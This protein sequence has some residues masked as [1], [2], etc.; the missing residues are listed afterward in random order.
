MLVASLL[1]WRREQKDYHLALFIYAAWR[2]LSA[3]RFSFKVVHG[4]NGITAWRGITWA[5]WAGGRRTNGEAW[6]GDDGVSSVFISMLASCP[7]PHRRLDRC[8]CV[9]A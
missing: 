9:F 6:Q 1:P 4:G 3:R 5:L 7:Y 8:V 2:L